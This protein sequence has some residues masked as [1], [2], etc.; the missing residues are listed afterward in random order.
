MS[1]LVMIYGQSG[2]GKSTTAKI[3]A[4]RLNITYLDTGSM[5]R[6]VTL[7]A[8]EKGLAAIGESVNWGQRG[9]SAHFRR[10][11]VPSSPN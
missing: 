4:K 8:L 10:R 6:A 9:D 11:V 5:Y 3:I 2:T 7:A 1:V